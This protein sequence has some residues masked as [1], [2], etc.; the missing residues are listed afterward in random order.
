MTTIAMRLGNIQRVYLYIVGGVFTLS[1]II[2][3]YLHHFVRVEGEFG[4][5]HHPVEPLLLKVHGISAALML[6]GFGSVLPGHIPR[7]W[8]L[9]RNIATGIIFFTVM[10]VLSLSGYFLYYLSDESIRD[11]TSILHWVLGLAFPVLAGIHIWRGYVSRRT[12]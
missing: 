5:L 7:A 1:G 4:L 9:N 11:F 10:T 8:A 12:G 2:W 6:I 3:V